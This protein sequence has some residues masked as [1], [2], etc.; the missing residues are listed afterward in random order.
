MAKKS[1][2]FR[3]LLSQQSTDNI[4]RQS[5]EALEKKLARDGI[6]TKFIPSPKGGN[7]SDALREIVEPY[8]NITDDRESVETLFSMGMFAWNLAVAAKEDRQELFDKFQAAV[9]SQDAE[10]I[11][12]GKAL[13][14]KLI[15][16]KEQLFPDNHRT[17]MN[18]ELKYTGR[19]NYHISVAST[20]G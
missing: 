20:I 12:E 15:E 16:R 13:I 5:L 19:G 1:K 3:E 8:L 7:I 14:Q 18:F 17:I 9:K 6:S 10:M 4:E 11:E 2:G